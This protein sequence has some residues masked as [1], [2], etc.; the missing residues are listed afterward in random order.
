VSSCWTVV[1][2]EAIGYSELAISDYAGR[3]LGQQVPEASPAPSA[4]LWRA[5]HYLAHIISGKRAKPA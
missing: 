3:E 4:R 1:R 5:I 2:S